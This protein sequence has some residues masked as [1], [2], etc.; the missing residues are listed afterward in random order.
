MHGRE[1]F[2]EEATGKK[3]RI[4]I[5]IGDEELALAKASGEPVS[6]YIQRL[7]R[8]DSQPDILRVPLRPG[9]GALMESS[10]VL[11]DGARARLYEALHT[12]MVQQVDATL[13]DSRARLMA[14]TDDAIAMAMAKK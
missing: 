11:R 14:I 9:L 6:S 3:Q 4:T 2:V 5:T 7:I 10:G 13:L 1:G 8:E 12:V